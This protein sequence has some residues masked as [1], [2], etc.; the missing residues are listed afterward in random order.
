MSLRTAVASASRAAYVSPLA[1]SVRYA[2][3]SAAASSSS[4]SSSAATAAAAEQAWTVPE[5][6]LG[7]THQ[8]RYRDHYNNSLASDLLYMTYNHRASETADK[9]VATAVAKAAAEQPKV[10]GY[11]ANRP[12]AKPRGNRPVK[13]VTKGITVER[14]PELESITLHTMVKAAIGSKHQLLTGI[15]LLRAISGESFQGG[16]RASTGVQVV[17]SRNG[18]AAFKLR[19]GMPVAAKVELR[20]DA[21]YDFIQSLVDF[22]LPRIREFPG[23]ELPAASASKTSPSALSGVVSFGVS[24]QAAALFPQVEANLDNYP[25]I[26]GFHMH[27]KTNAKGK[28]AQEFARTLLSGFRIPFHRK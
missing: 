2:S 3:S 23:I 13:Q 16:G 8:V 6:H 15:M 28:D 17:V 19:A 27:F 9:A 20:G 10:T 26:P 1:A 5:V 12:N 18:A 21:M 25:R 22:V 14:I 24:G 7:P 4:S 11:E